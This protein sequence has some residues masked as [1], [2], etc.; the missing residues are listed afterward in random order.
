VRK[1]KREGLD[2]GAAR[3][4]ALHTDLSELCGIDIDDI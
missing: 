1:F 2:A 4:E 3:I